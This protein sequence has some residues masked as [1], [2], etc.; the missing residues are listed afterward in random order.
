ME[1]FEGLISF[2]AAIGTA[3]ERNATQR[4]LLIVP[5][6]CTKKNFSTFRHVHS[7]MMP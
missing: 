4:L 3:V 2:S 1:E 7:T 5:K 6:A